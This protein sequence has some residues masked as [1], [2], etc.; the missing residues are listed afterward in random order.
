VHR[1]KKNKDENKIKIGQKSPTQQRH[2]CAA[3]Q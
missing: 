1:K 2:E 3:Q